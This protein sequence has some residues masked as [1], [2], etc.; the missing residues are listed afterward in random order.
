MLNHLSGV[1]LRFFPTTLY[2]EG[3]KTIRI[4]QQTLLLPTAG[5]EPGLPAQRTSALSNN[6]LPLGHGSIKLKSAQSTNFLA[7]FF[8]L[9][10][11]PVWVI[12]DAQ[13]INFN[14]CVSPDLPICRPW[15]EAIRLKRWRPTAWW[16]PAA[17]ERFRSTGRP[18]TRASSSPRRCW[19][20]SEDDG[21]RL[22][23]CQ[24]LYGAATRNSKN[25]FGGNYWSS[26]KG[27]KLGP[28]KKTKHMSWAE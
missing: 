16:P 13:M 24:L 21:S 3:E 5:I 1:W 7:Q 9:A 14:P 12:K 10:S 19:A 20:S 11:K 2:R 6:P 15:C 18:S 28:R 22:P 27:P 25:V 26:M 4:L 17:S 23:D 8:F